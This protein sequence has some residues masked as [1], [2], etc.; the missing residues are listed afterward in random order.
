MI[1]AI[2]AGGFQKMRALLALAAYAALT[3]AAFA[4]P[5]QEVTAED[6]V[7]LRIGQTR[8]FQFDKPY[9]S[10]AIASDAVARVNVQ[11]DRTFTVLGAG[12]GETL[13]TINFSDDDIHKMS[14]MVGGRTVRMYGTGLDGKDYVGFFCTSTD[15]GRADSD[16]PQPTGM[17]V[18]KRTRN[19]KGDVTTTTKQY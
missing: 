1:P 16:A 7:E 9:K 6:K 12:P 11:T 8:T 13:I 10:F 3:F 17:T 5:P 18:E 15:C 4:Q 2:Q 14:V 19:S